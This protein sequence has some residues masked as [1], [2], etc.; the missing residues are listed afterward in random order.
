MCRASTRRARS[1][2]TGAQLQLARRFDL[3]VILHVRSADKL[4]KGLRD[5]PVRGGIAHAF[6]G[7]LQQ[8]QAFI[9]L[10]FKLVTYGKN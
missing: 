7:S 6:N 1:G 3:P 10:G 5:V 8:G 9:A 2:F 4:L